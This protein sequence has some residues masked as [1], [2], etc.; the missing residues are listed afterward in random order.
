M[1]LI[2]IGGIPAAG[3]TTLGKKLGEEN[4]YLSLELEALR[5]DF[6]KSDLEKN[7]FSY[8]NNQKINENE[9]FREYYLRALIYDENVD[10]DTFKKWNMD[11][12]TYINKITNNIYNE[13]KEIEKNKDIDGLKEFICK[14]KNLI[15]YIPT[16]VTL[17]IIDT[18]IIS[19]VLISSFDIAK[20]A[21]K[22]I[23]LNVNKKVCR[24]RF[25]EREKIDNNKYDNSID[26]YLQ[27]CL[28]C[29]N[30]INK[31][32]IRIKNDGY[33]FHFRVAAVIVQDDKFLIQQIDGYDYYI[34]PGGH[35]L[36]GESSLKALEREVREEVGCDI[37]LEKC[38]LFCLHENFY[39][40]KEKLEH[41][42]ENY[43]TV[44]TKTPLPNNNWE[45]EENDNGKIKLL[46]FKWVSKNELKEL[47]LKPTTIKKLLVDNKSNE[48]SYLI[49]GGSE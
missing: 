13:L 24:E 47:D 3:K 8:T 45:I 6:L 36:L 46:H 35:A 21:D 20:L 18:I 48:F 23:I 9:T 1:R 32:D 33:N 40:K 30:D 43:F 14:Y 4:G 28:E 34:L 10:K 42:I 5:W 27:G 7:V 2:T 15:N 29:I 37:D 38:K 41:W 16:D 17:E 22:N 49:D 39:N 26:N 19:H 31:K 44:K 11:A 25:K 12:V